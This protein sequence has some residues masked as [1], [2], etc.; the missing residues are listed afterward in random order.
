MSASTSR[1]DGK[2]AVHPH[3]FARFALVICAT[4]GLAVCVLIVMTHW[5][6][7]LYPDS[8]VYVGAARA[9]L[10][11]DGVRFLND[12]GEIAPVTQYPPLYS[13]MIAGLGVFGVDPLEGARWI[14]ILFYAA[15]AVL[16]AWIVFRV[17]SS[18][19]ASWCACFL[20][21]SAF[22]MIYVHTQALTEPIFIFFV[23]WALIVLREYLEIGQESTLYTAS[24]MIGASCLVRYVGIAFLAI[25]GIA[26]LLLSPLPTVKRLSAAVKF[27]LIASLPL[28][29]WV[30]R[31]LF[32]AGNAVN[33]S[34][35]F[36][37]P[38]LSDLLPAVDTAGYWLLPISVVENIPWLS[39]TIIGIFGLAIV[40]LALRSK[41]FKT[42][43]I[44][45][46]LFWLVGYSV[47][48]LVS[49]SL[50]D[51]SLFFD[52]RTLALPYVI[53]MTL[54]AC[55]VASE[56][57]QIISAIGVRARL[58]VVFLLTVQ[59]ING[60]MWLK[61]SYTEG[62]GFATEQWRNSELI[63]FVRNAREPLLIF[64]NAPDFL[65]T[66]ANKPARMI[67]HKVNPENYKP[68]KQYEAELNTMREALRKPNALLLYFN[69]DNRL[70]YL[71]SARELELSMPLKVIK[72]ESD[73]KIYRLESVRNNSEQAAQGK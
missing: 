3:A 11:G 50:N 24:L 44:Q 51:Q 72:T 16:A 27:G 26:I 10:N 52:T 1:F 65:A 17:T 6:I 20:S 45:L 23:L 70:W 29:S 21:L 37:P 7:G 61:Q 56:W 15:N 53:V 4:V 31:N 57:Q 73:G 22:P 33:R 13:M 62:I 69:D 49:M 58:L 55:F 36:H 47:F 28:A 5:G 32:A 66:L 54:T 14:S 59:M 46:L 39:R 30:A 64:S 60:I 41:Y 9:I 42:R 25:G 34:F 18:I 63:G 19:G 67:P 35:G 40:W 68:N 38:A 2:S 71:P 48:L 8:I 12:V 43:Y